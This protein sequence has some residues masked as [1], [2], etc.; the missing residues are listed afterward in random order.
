[1]LSVAAAEATLMEETEALIA[2]AMGE[3]EVN[4]QD[5][6]PDIIQPDPEDGDLDLP[7][8]ALESQG[9]YDNEGHRVLW[10]SDD[11]SD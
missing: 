11:D 10:L 6:I 9:L 8:P 4:R 2:K 5:E 7:V 3:V 1:M